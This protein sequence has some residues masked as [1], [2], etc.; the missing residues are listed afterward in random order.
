VLRVFDAEAVS[1]GGGATHPREKIEH[2][3]VGAVAN[4]MDRQSNPGLVP[5]RHGGLH[6]GGGIHERQ[7]QAVIAD[8]QP[9]ADAGL[10]RGMGSDFLKMGAVKGFADGSLGSRTAWMFDFFSDDSIWPR[11]IAAFAFFREDYNPT[12]A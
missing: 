12:S 1:C 8:W 2:L 6:F 4:G 9:L 7:R 10:E 5:P 11:A 3:G